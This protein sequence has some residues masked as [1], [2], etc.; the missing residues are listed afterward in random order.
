SSCPC[1]RSGLLLACQ[2]RLRFGSVLVC[3]F[4]AQCQTAVLFFVAAVAYLQRCKSRPKLT[5][6]R[7]QKTGIESS[8][9]SW[10]IAPFCIAG[11]VPVRRYSTL[12]EL[13]LVDT[14]NYYVGVSFA[15]SVKP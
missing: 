14:H 5:T 8:P 11:V 9:W 6:V 4:V 7:Q 3:W 2:T 13:W 12:G 15:P 1:A 10:S